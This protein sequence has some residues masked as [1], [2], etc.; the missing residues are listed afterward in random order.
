M[1]TRK[2]FKQ[3]VR[4]RMRRTGEHYSVARR[5]VAG[6]PC[7]SR[8]GSLRGGLDGDTSAFADVLA[9]SAWSP[10]TPATRSPRP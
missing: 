6:S 4:D 1:T 2:H 10:R 5:R 8:T 3:L 9:T 7:R